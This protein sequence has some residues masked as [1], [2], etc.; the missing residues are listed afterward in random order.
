[1]TIRRLI[2]SLLLS[3]CGVSGFCQ[4]HRIAVEPLLKLESH[5]RHGYQPME[6]IADG[7]VKV[8]QLNSTQG[9]DLAMLQ[10]LQKRKKSYFGEDVLLKYDDDSLRAATVQAKGMMGHPL[11]FPADKA[12]MPVWDETALYFQLPEVQGQA[13][14]MPPMVCWEAFR[15]DSLPMMH[16]T[17]MLH[18]A[19]DAG[20]AAKAV[21]ETDE[22]EVLSGLFTIMP[23]S[24]VL[25]NIV[26][27]HQLTVDVHGSREVFVPMPS[28]DYK[29]LTLTLLDEGGMEVGRLEF[30]SLSI[31]RGHVKEISK[32]E[33][34]LQRQEPCKLPVLGG[35][36]V[37][38]NQYDAPMY[39]EV[40]IDNPQKVLASVN[41][42]NVTA[43]R[44]AR[45]TAYDFLACDDVGVKTKYKTARE[46][47]G[48]SSL[49]FDSLDLY[50][51]YNVIEGG[52]IV[53]NDCRSSKY[54]ATKSRAFKLYLTT[55]TSDFSYREF[56][57][58]DSLSCYIPE[59]NKKWKTAPLVQ[60]EWEFIPEEPKPGE[61]SIKDYVENHCGN[62]TITDD[63]HS[64]VKIQLVPA[65]ES[66]HKEGFHVIDHGIVEY[67]AATVYPMPYETHVQ[68]AEKPKRFTTDIIGLDKNY[69]TNADGSITF[70]GYFRVDPV[71]A[72]G[73]SIDFSPS[74]F[75]GCERGII[76][77]DTGIYGN[78]KYPQKDF[79]K[80]MY[81]SKVKSGLKFK[82]TIDKKYIKAGKKYKFWSYLLIGDR[83]FLGNQA[84]REEKS[85]GG[86]EGIF[87]RLLK[88]YKPYY[89]QLLDVS[90]GYV[91]SRV[92][93]SKNSGTDSWQQFETQEKALINCYSQIAKKLGLKDNDPTQKGKPVAFTTQGNL[94]YTVV[95]VKKVDVSIPPVFPEMTD[96]KDK[97]M[98]QLFPKAYPFIKQSPLVLCAIL[99]LKIKLKKNFKGDK[100]PIYCY[101]PGKGPDGKRMG[102]VYLFPV[103]MN[104]L[105][106]G[107]SMLS[108]K[109]KRGGDE[110]STL[111][112]VYG[113]G[114]PGYIDAMTKLV[115]T[116]QDADAA[117]RSTRLSIG[118]A[119]ALHKN[120][121]IDWMDGWYKK[122][123]EDYLNRH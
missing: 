113:W 87:G 104:I 116:D 48:K 46:L 90:R 123:T 68:W 53:K 7:L 12:Y 73:D 44:S 80:N 72:E 79:R 10:E 5:E 54:L 84:D 65:I 20:N 112:L 39:E 36:K 119:R 25:R 67:R 103:D 15:Q 111:I 117:R 1:M 74:Y 49:T 2:L 3:I 58:H 71:M 38:N 24:P 109:G 85:V 51:G 115:F 97:P 108:V 70:T 52:A 22:T 77:I 16:L 82:T 93:L 121:L 27:S 8:R 55:H 14:G 83:L 23:G 60:F 118:G 57:Y 28:G 13:A 122:Q 120:P 75:N 30:E 78:V 9:I 31:V 45:M 63:K 35:F 64:K 6:R 18:I 47:V 88:M 86:M 34:R 41:F 56:T 99:E 107:Q 19:F 33:V 29:T 91:E 114:T 4:M 94:P 61:G 98:A 110:A 102:W 43:I 96:E 89:K 37:W 66:A 92:N 76:M 69:Q 81:P 101:V 95:S 17:G 40:V 50:P 42:F 21:F 105:L 26:P 62:K 106:A 100:V 32:S 11:F 59:W